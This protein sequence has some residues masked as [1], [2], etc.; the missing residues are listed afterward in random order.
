[1]SHYIATQR[2]EVGSA[3]GE[4]E[5]DTGRVGRGRKREKKLESTYPGPAPLFN[6]HSR[7]VPE[8]LN[9]KRKDYNKFMQ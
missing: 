6:M 9:K 8:E 4:R 3:L 5:M 7:G 2:S 1:M